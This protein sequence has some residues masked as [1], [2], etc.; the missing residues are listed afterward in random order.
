M[1][2]LLL[3]GDNQLAIDERVRDIRARHD[4]TGF[5]TSIFAAPDDSIEAIRSACRSPG[6]FGST[7]L[8]IVYDLS[9]IPTGRRGRQEPAH[10]STTLSTLFRDLPES[11]ILVIV[12]RHLDPAVARFLKDTYP[13]TVIERFTTP[14]GNDLIDWTAQRARTHGATL[15]PN[16]AEL[17]LSALFPA[18]WR[19]ALPV[20]DLP[21]D[22]YRLDQELAKLALAAQP[23]GVVTPALVAELVSGEE[24]ADDWAL[25]A[26]LTAADGTAAIKELERMLVRGVEPERVLAQLVSHYEVFAAIASAPGAPIEEIARRTGLSLDRLRHCRQSARGAQ[27]VVAA[28]AF[29]LLR[30]LDFAAKRGQVDLATSFPAVVL[31]LTQLAVSARNVTGDPHGSASTKI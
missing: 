29:A 25:A 2:A 24:A 30:H 12:E 13:G 9:L 6:F 31:R 7:R 3:W 8:V 18:T 22:L 10:L 19:R 17:L 27:Q 26:A 21:P 14:R 4:P 5:A 1:M 16:V 20:A 11:T 28:S 23:D 15:D